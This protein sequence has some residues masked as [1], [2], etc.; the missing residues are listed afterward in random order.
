MEQRER[1]WP[2]NS[3]TIAAIVPIS[4]RK[5][6]RIIP[7]PDLGGLRY[8]KSLRREKIDAIERGD[9]FTT[10]EQLLQIVAVAKLFVAQ[11]AKPE[12]RRGDLLFVQFNEALWNEHADFL[13][14]ARAT[15]PDGGN[16]KFQEPK[17][18]AFR[19]WSLEFGIFSGLADGTH[20]HLPAEIPNSQ[21]PNAILYFG[22]WGLELG[23]SS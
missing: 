21:S 6:W 12:I 1:S 10:N 15:P 5:I 22:A 11:D 4:Q 17:S 16:P 23:I 13:S 3:V 19:A 8:P 20:R 14:T 7:T 9:D 18:Q 2:R